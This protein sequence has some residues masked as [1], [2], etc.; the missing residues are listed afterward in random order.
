MRDTT[1]SGHHSAPLRVLERAAPTSR[2][3]LPTRVV[4]VAFGVLTALAVV[5]LLVGADHTA[6]AFAWTI[7]PPVGAAVLGA[8]YGAGCLVVLL[9]LRAGS[10]AQAR[11]TLLTILVFTVLT[12][13]ATLLHLDRFHLDESAA[14]PRAAAWF[15]LAVYVLVPPAMSAVM[16]VQERARR[17]DGLRVDPGVGHPEPAP[18]PF[19]AS[20]VVQGLV[21]LAVG[22]SLFLTLEPV[23]SAWPWPLT[24]LV[25]QVIGAWLV[26]FGL[27]AFFAVR[28][29]FRLLRPAVTSYAAFGVLE[30]VALALHRD[31][32]AGGWATV[33]LVA[34][35]AWVAATGAWGAW[36]SGA[37]RAG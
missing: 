34:V 7:E 20:L 10:W 33:V 1:P 35:V 24:P 19:A 4:L 18:L 25:A 32:L 36:A 31:E 13:V 9:T 30:L 21:L 6:R 3:V 29:D 28:S 14:L 23:M 8:A 17:R 37:R 11:W 16:L 5:A 26:S 12:L 22:L 2:L 27:A 15:W